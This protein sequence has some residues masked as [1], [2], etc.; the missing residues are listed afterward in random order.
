MLLR[1]SPAGRGR[2]VLLGRFIKLTDCVS[3]ITVADVVVFVALCRSR[4][5]AG[6]LRLW[7]GGSLSLSRYLSRSARPSMT[8]SGPPEKNGGKAIVPLS[9]NPYSHYRLWPQLL[10]FS[11]SHKGW[12][13]KINLTLL[14]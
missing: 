6:M 13:R 12:L 14:V 9:S 5:N 4:V 11:K 1:A 10:L 7:Y 3:F 2:H 8:S